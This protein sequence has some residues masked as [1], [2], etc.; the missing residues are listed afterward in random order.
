MLD[1]V[2]LGDAGVERRAALVTPTRYAWAARPFWAFNAKSGAS[3]LYQVRPATSLAHPLTSWDRDARIQ[4]SDSY[5]DP[6]RPAAKRISSDACTSDILGPTVSWGAL[7]CRRRSDDPRPLQ[8][9]LTR[10]SQAVLSG[11]A[12][13]SR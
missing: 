11:T 13:I 9:D 2:H 1:R 6:F 4:G 10:R 3:F 5:V 7:R 8:A 12:S